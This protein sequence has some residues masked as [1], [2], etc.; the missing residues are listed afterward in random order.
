MKMF[1]DDN[2]DLDDGDDKCFRL[3]NDDYII[4]QDKYTTCDEKVEEFLEDFINLLHS[5][6]KD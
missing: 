5:N 4:E 3:F 1:N 2:S 6:K